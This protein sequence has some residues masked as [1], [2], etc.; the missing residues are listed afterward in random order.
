MD[1]RELI[2][3]EEDEIITFVDENGGVL[4]EYDVP[5]GER[6]PL[7]AD[8]VK[9]EDENYYYRF[10]GWS[11]YA[12]NAAG[13]NRSPVHTATF[14]REAKEKVTIGG[15]QATDRFLTLVVPVVSVIVVLLGVTVALC[16]HYRAWLMPRLRFAVS[17]AWKTIRR[18]AAWLWSRLRAGAVRLCAL[19]RSW[20]RKDGE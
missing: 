9:A 4:A 6:I 15:E 19:V 11:P 5:F 8:P 13:E 20:I 10:E 2:E 7:P 1:E 16:I 14:S 12:L 17:R 18:G 3:Q